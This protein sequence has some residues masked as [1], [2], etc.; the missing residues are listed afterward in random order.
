MKRLG[1]TAGLA[2]AA[3]FSC[4]ATASAN[5]AQFGSDLSD[6]SNANLCLNLCT[7]VQQ[8]QVGGSSPLPLT[9]PANGIITEWA[10]RSTDNVTYAF[11]ILRPTGVNT[12]AGAGTALGVDP[13]T[14][15]NAVLRYPVSIPVQKGDAIGIGPA[16]GDIDSGVPAHDTAAITANVW[17]TNTSGQPTDGDTATFTPQSGHE[18]LLQ[19]T[20]TFCGVPD[21]HKL[22]KVAAKR[23]LAAADCGVRVKKKVTQKRKF[24]GKVLKQKKT[25]GTT[26]SPGTVVGI[27]I[28][29]K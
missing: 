24:R 7:A 3:L 5:T 25:P 9:S 28:G 18:L 2:T 17:A 4:L 27:V 20:V 22:K 11:R 23:A 12:Y 21:V 19:A 10:I 14:T 13:E 29:Q 8:A 1:I 15:P 6:S 26:A 16:S